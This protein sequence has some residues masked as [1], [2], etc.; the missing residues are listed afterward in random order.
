MYVG[1]SLRLI[2]TPGEPLFQTRGIGGGAGVTDGTLCC[3]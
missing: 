1:Q 3:I 2:E